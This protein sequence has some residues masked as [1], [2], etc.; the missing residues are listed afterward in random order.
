MR[1]TTKG[2]GL[3]ARQF[4]ATK[5]P[6]DGLTWGRAIRRQVEIVRVHLPCHGCLEASVYNVSRGTSVRT[7]TEL[8]N[9]AVH[10]SKPQYYCSCL[11]TSTEPCDPSQ[12]YFLLDAMAR[13]GQHRGQATWSD[14]FHGTEPSLDIQTASVV[15]ATC[16]HID[17]M[18]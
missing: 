3:V 2:R 13:G 5:S 14:Y 12:V 9:T 17:S 10:F 11:L 6:R 1:R 8:V 4:T 16:L 7:Q 15:V 18:R